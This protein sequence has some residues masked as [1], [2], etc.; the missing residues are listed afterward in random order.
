MIVLKIIL[1]TIIVFIILAIPATL[2]WCTIS[3]ACVWF[4]ADVKIKFKDFVELY[5]LDP[6]RWILGDDSPKCYKSKSYSTWSPYL[7]FKLSYID[8]YRYQFWKYNLERRKKQPRA[9]ADLQNILESFGVD[10]EINSVKSKKGLEGQTITIEDSTP[11][12]SITKH[13]IAYLKEQFG[14]DRVEVKE[15]K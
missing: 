10:N 2:L 5:T 15:E 3:W 12:K 13:V 6:S 1:T 14:E 4:D 11:D 8:F 9:Q 7:K